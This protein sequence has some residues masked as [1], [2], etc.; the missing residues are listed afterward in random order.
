MVAVVAVSRVVQIYDLTPDHV[1]KGVLVHLR[2][3]CYNKEITTVQITEVSVND[4]MPTLVGHELSTLPV[5]AVFKDE[6]I[7]KIDKEELLDNLEAGMHVIC[8]DRRLR[9]AILFEFK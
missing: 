9:Q 4:D 6:A 1:S 5:M 2:S 3:I 8:F 7:V